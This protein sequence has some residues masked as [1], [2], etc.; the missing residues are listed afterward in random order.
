M[1]NRLAIFVIRFYQATLSRFLSGRGLCCRYHPTCSQYG[2]LAYE[3][4][5]FFKATWLMWQRFYDCHPSGKRPF[6]DFP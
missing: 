3:K 5:G 4:Y 1:L 2:V 6:I